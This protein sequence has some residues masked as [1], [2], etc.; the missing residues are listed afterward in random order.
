LE[1]FI[2][3][4]SKNPESFAEL[5]CRFPR[6]IAWLR[7][8]LNL[9]LAVWPSKKCN[10]PLPVDSK[11]VKRVYLVFSNYFIESPASF[12]GHLFLRFEV[13]SPEDRHN[14]F[15]D[16]VVNFSAVHGDVNY[17]HYMAGGLFG[18]FKGI[19]EVLPMHVKIQ[20]YS[21]HESRDLW[22]YPLDLSKEQMEDLILSLY[23]VSSAHSDYYY[24]SRNCSLLIAKLLETV[25][26]RAALSAY[27]RL[28]STPIDVLQRTV[29]RF[30]LIDQATFHPSNRTRYLR[31][32]GL[33]SDELHDVLH[34]IVDNED[35]T[36]IEKLSSEDQAR[37]LDVLLDYI[38]FL[39][40][41]SGPAAPEK[42]LLLRQKSL[43][44]RAKIDFRGVDVAASSK[45][46][47]DDELK[48]DNPMVLIPEQKFGLGYW[49]QPERR[50]GLIWWRPTLKDLISP[51]HGF[52]G[53]MGMT[54]FD[55]KLV[56]DG[57][58]FDLLSFDLINVENYQPNLPLRSFLNMNFRASYGY[59]NQDLARH[60]GVEIATSLSQ[61]FDLWWI[62]AY[63]RFA[64]VGELDEKEITGSRLLLGPSL[65][66]LLKITDLIKVHGDA[67]LLFYDKSLEALENRYTL[68][69]ALRLPADM[70]LY[71]EGRWTDHR[72]RWSL[73]L[74]HYF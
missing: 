27:Y 63:G 60:K 56:T 25:E 36:Y 66:F 6:R 13:G 51:S 17:F 43:F 41:L 21:N 1:A 24:F 65:G 28:W 15:L 68:K 71:F 54:M 2:R 23:E 70:E 20:Q 49:H 64:T 73:T 46:S 58:F 33:L 22:E 10:A 57:T 26:S 8:Q 11:N 5:Q 48:S 59:L 55:L 30:G 31:G 53:D 7:K 44:Q 74:N 69:S 52:H 50:V 18:W 32:Y 14:L 37:V 62:S 35:L 19:F 9:D 4:L 61:G 29:N 16:P 12:Y 45:V 42:M 40:R 39:N 34:E 47:D 3:E 72:P 38:D 67:S